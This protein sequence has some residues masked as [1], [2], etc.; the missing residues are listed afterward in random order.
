MPH[1][2]LLNAKLF[3]NQFIYISIVSERYACAMKHLVGGKGFC[4]KIH[5]QHKLLREVCYLK[6]AH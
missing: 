6:K 1:N 4:L 5:V 2:I 3:P